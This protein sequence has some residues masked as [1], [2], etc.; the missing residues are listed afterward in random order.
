MGKPWGDGS[1]LNRQYGPTWL[2]RTSSGVVPALVHRAVPSTLGLGRNE[3]KE[4]GCAFPYRKSSPTQ[5]AT[6]SS[7]IGRRQQSSAIAF[8]PNR[9]HADN[10]RRRTV[11]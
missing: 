2:P 1:P 4:P 11:L 8:T 10:H 3:G 6:P 5:P 7:P 9:P